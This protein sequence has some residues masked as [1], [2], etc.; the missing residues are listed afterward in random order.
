MK[1]CKIVFPTSVIAEIQYLTDKCDNEVGGLLGFVF[2]PSNV[3]YCKNIISMSGSK[4]SS[5][6]FEIPEDIV[7]KKMI[8]LMEAGKAFAVNG[9][10]HSHVNMNVWLSHEDNNT[11]DMLKKYSNLIVSIVINKKG[12]I[13]RRIDIGEVSIDD[14]DIAIDLERRCEK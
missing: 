7:A 5:S 8:E 14:V 2:L 12:E 1:T 10:W 11:I 13:Y 6:Y 9:W 3:L 4:H